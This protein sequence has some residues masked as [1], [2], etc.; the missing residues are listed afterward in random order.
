MNDLESA[1]PSKGLGGALTCLGV[2]CGAVLIL[3]LIASLAVFAFQDKLRDAL[4]DQAYQVLEAGINESDLDDLER[5]EVL[6]QFSRIRD[7]VQ[8]G[9]VGLDEITAFIQ[10]VNVSPLKSLLI[11]SQASRQL[12]RDTNFSDAE[13]SESEPLF[14]R[15][16]RGR[17]AGTFSS[18]QD[19]EL[20]KI[21]GMASSE[22]SIEIRLD[23]KPTSDAVRAAIQWIKTKVEDAE[24][25]EGGQDPDL[26]GVLEGIIDPI[27]K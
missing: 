3:A 27:L 13:R 16:M 26:S 19:H 4:A 24:I 2:G 20:A 5:G 22:N 12:R 15:Y 6:E 8:A 25:P 9:E 7:G 17:V 18:E 1:E 14:Q 11:L 23:E 10:Q 21:L